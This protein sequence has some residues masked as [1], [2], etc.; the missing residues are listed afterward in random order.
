MFGYSE[1]FNDFV[2]EGAED[3]DF[4]CFTDDPKLSS[5]FWQMKVVPSGLLDPARTAKQFKALPHRFLSDYDWS[6]YID[7]TVRLK[8]SPRR[9]FDEYLAGSPSPYVCFH[10]FERKCVYDE[11]EA[12]LNSKFDDPT[13]VHEQMS[14]YRMLGYPT[15]NGLAKGAFIL[16]Q[17]LD[18]LLRPVMGTLV[19][20][21]SL[22]F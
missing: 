4:I 14:Y 8:A 3:I 16:R 6:L 2:Y 21:H 18:P 11:A 10:H 7:N 19:S 17:H 1:R 12:V 5:A 22:V 13:I 15:N 20:A 9:I